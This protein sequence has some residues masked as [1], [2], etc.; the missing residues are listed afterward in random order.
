MMM[1]NQV[2]RLLLRS[3]VA[4]KAVTSVAAAADSI[5]RCVKCMT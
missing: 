4:I 3:K 1:I 2:A 5:A